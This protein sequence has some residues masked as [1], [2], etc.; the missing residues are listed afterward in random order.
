MLHND[1][2]LAKF[3][4]KLPVHTLWGLCYFLWHLYPCYWSSSWLVY[5]CIYFISFISFILY[6]TVDLLQ[7]KA[8]RSFLQ[9][10]IQ[11]VNCRTANWEYMQ[12]CYFWFY[13]PFLQKSF[14][15]FS[16]QPFNYSFLCTCPTKPN[17]ITRVLKVAADE[18]KTYILQDIN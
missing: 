8:F 4:M 11:Q 5:D 16:F 14:G 10:L 13:C 7:V 15:C 1:I 12:P 3:Y 2:C 18:Y 9:C 6:L 17:S